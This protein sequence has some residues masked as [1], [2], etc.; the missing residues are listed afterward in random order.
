M[1]PMD[2][3]FGRW[4]K[5]QSPKK[6]PPA[7][8]EDGDIVDAHEIPLTFRELLVA[9]VL[10]ATGSFA[11]FSNLDVSFRSIFPVYL[12]TPMEMGGL[13]LDPSAIGTVMAVMGVFGGIS[14]L[15]FFTPLYNRLGGRTLF[16]ITT[17]LFFPIAALFPIINR[18]GQEH[19]LHSFAWLLVGLQIFLFA[20]AN[21][22][23]S[24]PFDHFLNLVRVMNHIFRSGVTLVY[25]NAAAPNRASIGAINGLAQVLMCVMRAI[26]PSAVN[27]AFAL[28]I[29]KHV[30]GGHFAY[31]VL[32]GLAAISLAVGAALPKRPLK[33]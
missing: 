28:G 30:M 7:V 26:G 29:E 15:L 18:V 31:W 9:P 12:A 19:G 8:V 6:S 33:C 22:A 16:L 23:T 17:S 11:L 24:K 32:A 25:I 5:S 2:Y 3:L 4:H 21:F 13:G 10:I 20:F 27:S 1:S 14:P